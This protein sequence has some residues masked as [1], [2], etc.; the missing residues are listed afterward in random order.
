MKLLADI[1]IFGEGGGSFKGFGPLGNPGEGTA[2]STFSK[3]ISS[4]IGLLT[5]I[6]IIWFVFLLLGGAIGIMTSGGD[7]Q[8]LEN[9]QKRITTGLIGLIVIVAGIFIIRF[10]GSLIG[11]PDILNIYYL[12]DLIQIK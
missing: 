7:K 10:I 4:T 12:Y 9:A 11:I 6:A 5:V 3:F 8:S 1:S 2:I